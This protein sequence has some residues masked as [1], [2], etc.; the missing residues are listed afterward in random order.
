MKV[1]FF[2]SSRCRDCLKAFVLLSKYSI[3]IEYIDA[4]SDETQDLCDEEKVD[5]LPHLQFME[6]N[7][8]IVENIGPLD[9]DIL[10][11]ILMKYFSN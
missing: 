4:F 6:N 10:T 1:R 5:Q 7:K 9:S 2:G 11:N 3:D 8:T